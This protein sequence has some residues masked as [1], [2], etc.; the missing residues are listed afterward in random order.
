MAMRR[1]RAHV[2]VVNPDLGADHKGQRYC[3]HCPLGEH[4][5]IHTMPEQHADVTAA[6]ARRL[7]EREDGD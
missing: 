2:F 1:V 6:E 5:D 7:G 4:H 3:A